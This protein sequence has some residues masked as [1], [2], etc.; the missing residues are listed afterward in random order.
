MCPT[1]DSLLACAGS[2]GKDAHAQLNSRMAGL[3]LLSGR[4][5][6]C[7]ETSR[8]A[9]GKRH[10]RMGDD[11]IATAIGITSPS[12]QTAIAWAIPLLLAFITLWVYH[13]IQVRV[14]QAP[15]VAI[16]TIGNPQRAI[17]DNIISQI[18]RQLQV[19]A[20]NFYE[21]LTTLYDLQDTANRGT[22]ERVTSLLRPTSDEFRRDVSSFNQWIIDSTNR[23]NKHRQEVRQ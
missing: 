16:H 5:H 22:L 9:G 6:L 2:Q 8:Q 23:M 11:Q 15:T 3:G 7:L 10:A 12:A 13:L 14:L 18:P 20:N 21:G 19:A 4:A 17:R 1:P